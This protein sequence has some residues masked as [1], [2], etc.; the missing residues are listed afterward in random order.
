MTTIDA[1]VG[2]YYMVPH[3]HVAA[4]MRVGWVPRN[5]WVPVIGPRHT[6]VEH[7]GIASEH[8]HV[9]WR[10]V[11]A[12]EF[13]FAR[14]GRVGSPLGHV[15]SS[16]IARGDLGADSPVLKRRLCRREMPAFPRRLLDKRF[17]ALESAHRCLRP[18]P[19][20]ICSHRGIDLRP[21]AQP[22]GTAI[23]P[24]HGLRWNLASGELVSHHTEGV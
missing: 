12:A 6:D 14:S 8:Y 11:G 18:K 15:L 4:D 7:I 24:G 23:C 1:K 10:F 9:D 20:G 19:G 17:G 13:E 2:L 16:C 3:M 5:G 22:D 21:F